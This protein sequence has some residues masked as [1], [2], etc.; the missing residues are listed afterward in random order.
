V[1]TRTKAWLVLVVVAVGSLIGVI[2][3]GLLTGGGSSVGRERGASLNGT[4][5]TTPWSLATT[6]RPMAAADCALGDGSSASSSPT[7]RA[8]AVEREWR[9]NLRCGALADPKRNFPNPSRARLGFRLWLAANRY[10]LRVVRVEILHP[11]QAAPLVVVK[12]NDKRALSS[13]M[14]AIL[15][16]INPKAPTDDDRTGW[17]YEG[18][19]FEAVDRDGIPFLA[20]FNWWRGPHAGGG[21]WAS[22]AA[23]LPFE[24][25]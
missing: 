19:M 23:L 11:R 10:H 14:A 20:T 3:S 8:V 25:G 6:I 16:L 24:H 18:F 9:A 2:V 12:V 13:S 1:R 7:A 21:Q 5:P 22:E 15:H 4:V 17:S